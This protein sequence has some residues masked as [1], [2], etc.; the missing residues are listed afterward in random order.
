MPAVFTVPS[1]F[2]AIDKVS[3]PLIAMQKNVK[4][5]GASTVAN[6]QRASMAFNRFNRRV[7]SVGKRVSKAVGT[8]GVAFGM[9]AIVSAVGGAINVFADFEQANAGLA[10]VM[11][12]TVEENRALTEDAKRLG[13]TTAKTATEVVGLQEA[14]ARL[15]FSEDAILNMTGATISGSV[16]MQ[17]ELA[18][19]AEL[20]GA[21]VKSF[22]DFESINAPTIIDQMT[23]ATQKSA[24]N[25]EKLQTGL[26]IVAGAANAAGIPFT[27]LLAL[28]GKLSDAGIDASSSSTA[29]R[30]IFIESA[31]RGD[32]YQ[33]ILQNIQKNQDKLTAANDKFGKRAA[34]SA[35]ILANNLSQIDDLDQAL[36]NAAGTA[37]TAANKQLNTLNGRLTILGSAY[38]GFILSLES[39]N[40]EFAQFLKTSVEVATE[41]L[42]MATGTAK[43]GT[44]LSSAELN[45]R[46]LALKAQKFIGIVTFLAKGY[47]LM[48]AAQKALN[49]SIKAYQLL[50]KVGH[51]FRFARVFISLAKAKGIATAA[52]KLLNISVLA[53]P[54]VLM[55][56]AIAAVTAIIWKLVTAQSAQEKVLEE[57]DQKTRELASQQIVDLD[58]LFIALNKTN[59]G[60][61]ERV[62]LIRQ[63]KDQYPGVNAEME[64]ELLNNKNLTKSYEFLRAEILKTARA[65]AVQ[66]KI[67]EQ[68]NKIVDLELQLQQKGIN[69]A[70]FLKEVQTLGKVEASDIPGF[71]LGVTEQSKKY[72]QLLEKFGVDEGHF[73]NLGLISDAWSAID[74][75]AIVSDLVKLQSAL[76]QPTAPFQSGGVVTDNQTQQTQQNTNSR[77]DLFLNNRSGAETETFAEGTGVNVQKTGN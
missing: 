22:D 20:V 35:S 60:S 72:Q 70:D 42:S 61:E 31:A 67:G 47:I 53:N 51:F 77:V 28:M 30:N 44:E 21:M 66:E 17:G 48:I 8:F 13:A 46:S 29:L 33:Q 27:K 40:G 7:Q 52:Q 36:Q 58:K 50:T 64:K 25:F 68:A 16:A 2:K 37:E 65:K 74:S 39:G 5:F 3:K 11:N 34:V 6:M 45:I 55:G 71:S 26:P 18:E 62:K 23:A 73:D 10:A 69:S 14:F 12:K 19:T 24:L 4:R 63:L 9:F 32:S 43:L 1:V 76:S 54:Y 38:E 75:Q 49:I 56:V 15:G 41:L 57:I 59:A